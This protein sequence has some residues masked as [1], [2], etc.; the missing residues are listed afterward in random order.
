MAGA[1]DPNAALLQK[2]FAEV[3]GWV[4]KSAE[5][6]PADKYGY[7]PIGTVRT[8]GQQIAHI[9]DGYNYFCGHAAGRAPEWSDAVEKG[10]GD[11][12]ALL[13]KLKE[14][15]DACAAAFAGASPQA[16]PLLGALGHTN[17]HYGNAIVYLRMLGL[18]PPSS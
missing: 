9:A 2:Q 10:P 11:K 12:A 7:A 1:E 6:V 15:T 3:S 4:T 8:F 18:V 17:L 16:A 13:A 5:L 14:A